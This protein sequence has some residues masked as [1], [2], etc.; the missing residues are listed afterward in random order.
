MK[1]LNILF[2]LISLSCY[3]Q[4]KSIKLILNT[5]STITTEWINLYDSPILSSPYIKIDGNNGDK[6]KIKDIRSYKGYD[7]FGNYKRLETIRFKTKGKYCFTEQTFKQDSVDNIKIFYNQVLF[8]RP[9]NSSKFNRVR[10]KLENNEIKDLNYKNVKIDFDYAQDKLKNVNH[11]R[12]AQIISASLGVLLLSDIILDH[13]DPQN[14][15]FGNKKD[16]LKF[17]ASGL[18]LT[19]PFTLEKAKQKRLIKIIKNQ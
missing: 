12:I 15:E 4:K 9:E 10:Y 8:G 18:L 16:E 19:F 11:L 14:A 5:D 3:S 1:Y 13:W 7:Q 6:I 17:I 2:I